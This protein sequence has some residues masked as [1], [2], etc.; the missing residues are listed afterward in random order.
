MGIHVE[1]DEFGFRPESLSVVHSCCRRNQNA[2]LSFT[3]CRFDLLSYLSF[4]VFGYSVD[5]EQTGSAQEYSW[6]L[7][8]YR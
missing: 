5:G 2:T 1:S 8:Q 4:E 7:R 3:F 6:V